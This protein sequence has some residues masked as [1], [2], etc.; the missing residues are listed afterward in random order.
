M[1]E[2][3]IFYAVFYGG[4]AWLAWKVGNQD[5]V[6]GTIVFF[7]VLSECNKSHAPKK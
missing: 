5:I 3:G 6:I 7:L 2:F 1:K 4:C